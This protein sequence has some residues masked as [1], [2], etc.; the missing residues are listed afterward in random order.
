[1]AANSRFF[2]SSREFCRF[3]RR[4][5]HSAI[6]TARQIKHLPAISRSEPNREFTRA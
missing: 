3:S 5:S 2:P 6:K 1:M 4:G